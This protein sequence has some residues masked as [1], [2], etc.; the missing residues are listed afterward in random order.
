MNV[1]DFSWLKNKDAL[2]NMIDAHRYY[3]NLILNDELNMDELSV[4]LNDLKNLKEYFSLISSFYNNKI[5]EI[6][7]G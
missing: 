3:L 1:E 2:K 7:N 5:N 6:E 4:C